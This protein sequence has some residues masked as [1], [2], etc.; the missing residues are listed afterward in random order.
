MRRRHALQTRC[1]RV[2]GFALYRMAGRHVRIDVT[3]SWLV[4]ITMPV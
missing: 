4:E 1:K 2:R 3:L